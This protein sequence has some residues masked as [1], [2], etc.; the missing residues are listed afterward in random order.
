[1]IDSI[2]VIC[3]GNICRSPMAEELFRR[4]LP[5]R[6]VSSAGLAA[7]VGEP[8]DPIAVELMR[9]RDF[10]IT[11]HRARQVQPVM[12]ADAGLVLVMELGHQ[13]YLE[14]QYPLARGKI[15]RLCESTKTDIAD[16]YRCGRAAFEEA[17]GLIDQGV[18]SW[19]ARLNAL[20]GG[21]GPVIVQ[22]QAER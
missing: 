19:A 3:V 7:L 15:F 18:E 13:R 2:L 21:R 8:A 14:R 11:A 22:S 4:A 12:V 16:P 1:M 6:R 5:A 20:A 17:M 9:D 10:D